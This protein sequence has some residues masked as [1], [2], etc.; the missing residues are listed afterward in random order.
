MRVPVVL[1][2][3][4]KGTRTV[5]TKKSGKNAVAAA[6][7]DADHAKLTRLRE[8]LPAVAVTGYFNAG[9]NGPIPQ[10]SYEILKSSWENE[11]TAGRA[12]LSFY[13]TGA[14]KL[15]S[16]RSTIAS[17]FNADISEVAITHSTGEGMNAAMQGILWKP[18][19]EIVTTNL[20]H[21]AL[22]FAAASVVQRFGLVMNTVDIGYGE[23]DVLARLKTAITPRTRL[24]MISHLQWSSG[25][26]MPIKEIAA[27]C[28]SKGILTVIDAAQGGG[29]LNV[30]FHDLD[31]DVYSMAGQK[32][33][34]GPNASGIMLVRKES[35]GHFR[36]SYVRGGSWDEFGYFTP[37]AGATRFE[38][39]EMFGPAIE[40]FDKGLQWLRDDVGFAWLAARNVALGKRVHKSL[41]RTKHVTVTT[42]TANMAGMICFNVAGMHPRDVSTAL[43]ER[44]Y[45]IRYVEARPC[46]TSARISASWWTTEDEVDGLCAAIAEVAAEAGKAK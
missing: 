42:P 28:R 44:G 29:Q 39:G 14:Q 45:T 3:H 34:L 19:D 2:R 33:L 10:V 15:A 38:N 43:A 30:D 7:S 18:G 1:R 41:S 21:P 35:L 6:P 37:A 26:V 8:Q 9:S 46:P 13:G 24:V 17:I 25:A 23:G 31:V 32:W 27:Y 22:F 20:E 16:L 11:F 5:A 4:L 36:P 40:A 12:S